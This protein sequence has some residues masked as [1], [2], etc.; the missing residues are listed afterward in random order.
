MF[1]CND[2]KKYFKEPIVT[3]PEPD[4]GAYDVLCPHCG[5]DDLGDAKMCACGMNPTTGDFCEDC[6][7]T[8][9]LVLDKLKADLGFTQ[10]DFEQIISNHFGW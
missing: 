4:T 8:V 3:S 9:R 1:R 7:E 2:C 5:G 6:Y 10:E